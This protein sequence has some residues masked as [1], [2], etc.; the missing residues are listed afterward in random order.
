MKKLNAFII[1]L[2][3]SIMPSF[4]EESKELNNNNSNS[5]ENSSD[6]KVEDNKTIKAVDAN[7]FFDM[8]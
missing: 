7:Q 3:F 6:K 4:S 8:I 2:C 5:T 1:I